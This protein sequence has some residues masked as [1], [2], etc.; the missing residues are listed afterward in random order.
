MWVVEKATK[1]GRL[2]AILCCVYRTWLEKFC[3]EEHPGSQCLQRWFDY[4]FCVTWKSSCASLCHCSSFFHR[5]NN[6]QW[7]SKLEIKLSWC[8][9]KGR[10]SCQIISI[11]VAL[12][13]L[14]SLLAV[15]RSGEEQPLWLSSCFVVRTEVHIW[16]LASAD[17]VAHQT[18]LQDDYFMLI[19]SKT[20]DKRQGMG[21]VQNKGK[22]TLKR[23]QAVPHHSSVLFFL[24][25]YQLLRSLLCFLI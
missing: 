19:Y 2:T 15:C 16:I 18:S 11:R 6:P 4:G 24:P 22:E 17:S 3:R 5:D 13:G 1:I 12:S 20:T 7:S 25:L 8:N 14:T 21:E 23:K 10:D 9:T